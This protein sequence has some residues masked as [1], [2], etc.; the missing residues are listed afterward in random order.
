MIPV[1]SKDAIEE[2][3]L[4]I[5]KSLANVNVEDAKKRM[6][7]IILTF[8]AKQPEIFEH[9]SYIFSFHLKNNDGMCPIQLLTVYTI[10]IINSLYIQNELDELKELFNFDDEELPNILPEDD[11]DDE[12]NNYN[13]DDFHADGPENP[14]DYLW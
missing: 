8:K 9:L 4:N 3:F 10:L 11:E 2:S 5:G 6:E 12:D 1:A 7:K 14:E 13:E